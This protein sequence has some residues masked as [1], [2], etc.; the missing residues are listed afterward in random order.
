MATKDGLSYLE[1]KNVL[2]LSYA[3][4]VLVFVLLKCEGKSVRGHP[5][6]G[7]LLEVRTYLDRMQPLDKKLAGQVAKLLEAARLAHGAGEG[8]VGRLAV[9]RA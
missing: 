9:S 3:M 8:G 1:V 4:Y 5:V 7:R 6:V 2:L